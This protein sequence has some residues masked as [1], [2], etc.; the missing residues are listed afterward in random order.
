[1]ACTPAESREPLRA[2][3]RHRMAAHG[4][5]RGRIE[6][7]VMDVLERYEKLPEPLRRD[8]ENRF[9]WA[10]DTGPSH[11]DATIEKALATI[12][13]PLL[14]HQR[15]AVEDASQALM[16]ALSWMDPD[17]ARRFM[18]EP[19]YKRFVK[20]HTAGGRR[21][22]PGGSGGENGVAA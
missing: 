9:M 6:E 14:D 10:L 20:L 2:A 21:S 15:G 7:D 18:A 12:V 11:P 8:M 5:I 3:A 4:P 17:T 1:M 13:G 16:D 19:S 22:H